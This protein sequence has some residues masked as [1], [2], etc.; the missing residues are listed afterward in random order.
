MHTQMPFETGPIHFVGIGGIGMSGIAEVM[1]N[2]GYQVQ[3]SDMRENPNVTR[4]KKLG[5]NIYIG[6]KS[7]QVHGAGAIV[8][9]S[10]IKSDNAELTEARALSIPVVRRAEMLAELMRLKWI[11][12]P[13]KYLRRSN[14]IHF[15]DIKEIEVLRILFKQRYIFLYII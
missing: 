10:A 12:Q 4:L 8:V 5:A 7:E 9:S 3:G 11:E 15:R 6:H 14:F 13:R 2:L 1:L